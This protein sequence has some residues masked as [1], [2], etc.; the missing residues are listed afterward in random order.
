MKSFKYMAAT[1]LIIASMHANA[2]LIVNGG[3]V[4]SIAA[5]N[6][7]AADIGAGQ[8]NIGGNLFFDALTSD[9]KVDLTFTYLDHEAG[10][11]NVF[12]AYGVG[13]I[14]NQGAAY[15]DSFSV[16]NVDTAAMGGLLDFDFEVVGPAGANLGGIANGSNAFPEA[17]GKSFAIILDT[18]FRGIAYDALLLWD[19]AG[20][21]SGDDDN[22]DD[23]IIGLTIAKVPEPGTLALFGLGLLGLGISRRRVS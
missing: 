3:S 23:H 14:S 1:G 2:G 12:S 6:D 19:D 8:Y 11:D 13:S 10:W 17:G 16:G 4:Q 21:G 5:G 22:H 7:F 9:P 18:T 20:G 15:L